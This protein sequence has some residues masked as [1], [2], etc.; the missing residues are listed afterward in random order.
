MGLAVCLSVLSNCKDSMIDVEL[1]ADRLDQGPSTNDGARVK[2]ATAR[3]PLAGTTKRLRD[4]HSEKSC[5]RPSITSTLALALLACNGTTSAAAFVG[6]WSCAGNTDG[7]PGAHWTMTLVQNADGTLSPAEV[8]G[9]ENDCTPAR[10][11][12]PFRARWRGVRRS[13]AKRR[14]RRRRSG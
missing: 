7:A 3:E 9:G 6:T 10:S 11:T 12:M 2:G 13:F 14:L 5:G 4:H 1:A 8:D